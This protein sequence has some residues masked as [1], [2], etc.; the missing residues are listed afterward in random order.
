M[1]DPFVHEQARKLAARLLKEGT[2]DDGRIE[3]AFLL[4]YGRPPTADEATETNDFILQV[5]PR[6]GKAGVAADQV[7]A[8]AWE[9]F[10]RVLFMSNEFVYVN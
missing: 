6:L 2:K 9:S 10:A 4:V 7:E 8:R 5:R 1:N 3:R